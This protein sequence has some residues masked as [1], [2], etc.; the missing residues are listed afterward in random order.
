MPPGHD[1]S[2]GDRDELYKKL[3]DEYFAT[4]SANPGILKTW[5]LGRGDAEDQAVAVR[6]EP[7]KS[8]D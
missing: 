6:R 2:E 8:G 1:L 7:N 5:L 4:D 3:V